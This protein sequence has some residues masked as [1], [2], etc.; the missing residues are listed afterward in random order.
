MEEDVEGDSDERVGVKLGRIF[1]SATRLFGTTGLSS[2][3][4]DEFGSGI[5]KPLA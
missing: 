2:Y 1:H 4:E 3:D 5:E